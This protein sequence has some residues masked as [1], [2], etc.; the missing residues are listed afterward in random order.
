MNANVV[1]AITSYRNSISDIQ[2]PKYPFWT[3]VAQLEEGKYYGYFMIACIWCIWLV[4]QF[5]ITIILLNFLIAIIVQSY[6]SVMSKSIIN[7]YST[8]AAWNRDYRII[9]TWLSDKVFTTLLPRK[10]FEVFLL[11]A[12][13]FTD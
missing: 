8:K 4:N 13:T 9:K 10:P 12:Q 6:E 11:S 2:V 1:F 7:I 3:E 5:F